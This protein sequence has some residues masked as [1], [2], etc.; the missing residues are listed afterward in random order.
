[1]EYRVKLPSRL[2]RILGQPLTQNVPRSPHF[3][4]MPVLICKTVNSDQSSETQSLILVVHRNSALE[5]FENKLISVDILDA[6]GVR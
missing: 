5:G 2:Y 4:Y 3:S 6:G 1:M